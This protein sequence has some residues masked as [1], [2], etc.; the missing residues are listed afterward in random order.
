MPQEPAARTAEDLER[1]REYLNV[2]ARLQVHQGVRHK[3]DLSGVVQQTLLEASQE[4]DEEGE[5]RS[6]GE[7]LAWLRVILNHNLADGLRR[8][9]SQKRDAAR[10]CSLDAALE[11]SASRL[12]RCLATRDPSPSQ[13][14]IRREEI[15]AMVKAL[16]RLPENQRRAIEMHH[17][18]GQP[19]ASIADELNTTKAAVAGLLHRGLKSLRASL[20]VD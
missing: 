17:L 5:T 10:D 15:M 8:I 16:A 12:A 13:R 2:L 6:E 18:W 1:Y 7:T 4:F 9:A 11:E 20:N 3:V 14:A 19:L